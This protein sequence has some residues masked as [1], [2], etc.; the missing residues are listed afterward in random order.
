MDAGICQ[1]NDTELLT[2]AG[3]GRMAV[4]DV[5]NASAGPTRV[6]VPDAK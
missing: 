4:F 3:D 5:R 2:T 1:L 6:A